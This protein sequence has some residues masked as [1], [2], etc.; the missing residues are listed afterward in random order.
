[1]RREV[2][3]RRNLAEAS[4][5]EGVGRNPVPQRI[6]RQVDRG[7]RKWCEGTST[8]VPMERPSRPPG[9]PIG[10]LWVRAWWDLPDPEA[11]E[12][13]RSD[14]RFAPSPRRRAHG[15]DCGPERAVAVP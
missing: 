14:L 7:R 11:E 10:A 2:E 15:P 12:A 8:L 1:M 9:V 3:R 6:D 13:L 4:L 5:P